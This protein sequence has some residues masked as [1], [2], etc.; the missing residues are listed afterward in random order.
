MALLLS[1]LVAASVSGCLFVHTLSSEPG[2]DI[3]SIKP[4]ISRAQVEKVVGAPLKEWTSSLGVR[5]SL[6]RYYGGVEPSAVGAGLVGF[7]DIIS[8]GLFELTWLSDKDRESFTKAQEKHPFM[9]VSYDAQDIVIGV[10]PDIGEFALLPADGRSPPVHTT[11][12][13]R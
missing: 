8:L 3:S 6:Y 11:P 9:A 4:G 1:L 12:R 2:I 5:F 7:L 13:E 10:F